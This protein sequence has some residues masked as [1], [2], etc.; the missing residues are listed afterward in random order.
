MLLTKKGTVRQIITGTWFI[1]KEKTGLSRGLVVFFFNGKRSL[2][3]PCNFETMSS[4]NT[5][6]NV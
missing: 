5:C 3:Q 1:D 6:N 4:S 2:N